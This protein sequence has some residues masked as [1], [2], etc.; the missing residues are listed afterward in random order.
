ML[1]TWVYR[2]VI[3]A[4]LAAVLWAVGYLVWYTANDPGHGTITGK[5]YD[6]PWVSCSGK[7]LVCTSYPECYRIE[8]NDGHHDGDACVSPAEYDRYRVG[9]Q[10]PEV[11]P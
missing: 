1:E 5:R 11:A 6:A 7:P 10:Y 4:I 2:L 8:Y 3:G 9:G